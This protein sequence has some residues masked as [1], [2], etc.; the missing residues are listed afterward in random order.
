MLHVAVP[1]TIDNLTQKTRKYKLENYVSKNYVFDVER[2]LKAY[3]KAHAKHDFICSVCEQQ[4]QRIADPKLLGLDIS[5]VQEQFG[6]FDFKKPNQAQ[7]N[8]NN[9]CSRHCELVFIASKDII[10]QEYGINS[11]QFKKYA[12][13]IRPEIIF[14]S[15]DL[16]I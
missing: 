16:E 10:N 6:N 2:S 9:L 14:T 15:K 11:H 5:I 8:F 4:Y 7:G 13:L 3:N 12:K 1:T